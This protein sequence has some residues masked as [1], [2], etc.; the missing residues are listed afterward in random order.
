[1]YVLIIGLSAFEYGCSV[2]VSASFTDQCIWYSTSVGTCIMIMSSKYTRR[3]SEFDR[4]EIQ[5][6]NDQHLVINLIFYCEH[7]LY[8]SKN[9]ADFFFFKSGIFL[10]AFFIIFSIFLSKLQ[11]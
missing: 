8:R 11:N 5:L 7:H 10:K 9:R 1:M 4:K 3:T 2:A 6:A